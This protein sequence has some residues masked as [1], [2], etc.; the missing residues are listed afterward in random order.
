MR[1]LL[2]LPAFAYLALLVLNLDIFK[3]STEINFFFITTFQIPV[4]IFISIFFILYILL[5]W[6]WFNFSSIFSS[7][8]T[9]RLEKEVF[10]LKSKLL[11]KQGELI[12]NIENHFEDVLGK[13]KTESDKKLE[14]YKKENDKIVSNIEYEMK[15]LK[16]KIDKAAKK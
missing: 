10:D 7:L 13:F 6:V 9:K 8:K 2:F 5:I 11:N 1:L 15:S 3:A 14:L 4:V 16:E 12:K